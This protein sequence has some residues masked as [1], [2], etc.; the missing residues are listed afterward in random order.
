MI[1]QLHFTLHMDFLTVSSLNKRYPA[2]HCRRSDD[3]RH[4]FQLLLSLGAKQKLYSGF[5]QRSQVICYLILGLAV[6]EDYLSAHFFSSE[7][8]CRT[9][10]TGTDNEDFLP[11]EIFLQFFF[12]DCVFPSYCVLL[13]ND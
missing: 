12:H 10:D 7:R 2:R 13:L 1:G 11:G 4:T 5:F 3:S 8:S 9:G 6:T